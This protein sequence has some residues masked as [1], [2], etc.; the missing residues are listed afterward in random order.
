MVRPNSPPSPGRVTFSTSLPVY[1]AL[2]GVEK[3]R[4]MT[5]AADGASENA[6]RM[7]AI[8]VRAIRC[9]I[10]AVDILDGV[11]RGMQ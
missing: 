6:L 3:L 9:I 10:F 4:V 5:V 11:R 7:G 8:V 2:C 1:K